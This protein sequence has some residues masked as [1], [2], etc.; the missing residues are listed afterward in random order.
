MTDAETL[1]FCKRYLAALERNA[2]GD[3]LAQFY[4]PDAVQIELPNRLMPQGARRDLQA[5]QE[6]AERGKRGMSAQRFEL[7]HAVV[8]GNE[9][10][11]EI[12]WTGALAVAF[13]GLP[14]GAEM[15]ARFAVFLELR[16]GRIAAQ[17]NYDCFDPW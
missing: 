2:T 3:E 15:R 14:E 1:E 16:D 5:M 4:T 6:A 7:L 8:K 11:L 10:V 9:V 17:R 13:A 12:Q